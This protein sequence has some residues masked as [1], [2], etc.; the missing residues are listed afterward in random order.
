MR[1][2]R[3]TEVLVIGGGPAGYVAAIRLAQLGK[4]VLL[5]EKE[6]VGG[7]CVNWGCIPVKAL[8]HAAEVVRSAVEARPMGILFQKP[9]LDILSLYGWKGRIVER[10]VRGVEFLLKAN[11]VETLRGMARFVDYRQVE[12]IL[13]DG[14]DVLVE[15]ENVLVATGSRPVVLPGMETDGRRVIDSSGA[16]NVVDLP[17]RM[18][19]IGAGVIGLEFATIFSRLGSKVTVLELVDQVLP[20]TD[21]EIASMLKRL[22]SREGIDFRLG[23][24]VAGI[25]AG[26][27][28]VIQYSGKDGEQKV[29]TD[30]VLVAVGRVPL[31]DGLN[32]EAAGVA[33]DQ[34]G[35]I[36]TDGQLRTNVPNVSAIGDVRGGMLLAHKAMAEGI[37]FADNL[38]SGRQWS[39]K[40]VPAC[41][42]TDPEVAT[43]GMTEKEA[44]DAGRKVR[45]SRVPLSAIGRSLT[46]GRSEG[47]CKMVV[48]SD[49]DRVLGVGMVAP[50]ADALIA[51]AAVAVELGLTAAQIGSVVHPHPTMSELLFEAAEATHGRAV[52]IV[53]K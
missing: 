21:P 49:S 13:P 53:N 31:T 37:A 41:V 20:G 36:K 5:V 3:R 11:G 4:K 25:T 2:P 52:H 26:E 16:L 30:R 32:L 12:V 1:V 8:L 46:L 35:F 43:V 47:L 51:E 9:E 23:V 42:Y 19:V 29:E 39:F 14:S 18:V 33:V 44:V 38:A 27:S 22:M 24:K 15:A 7:V 45:V 28:P 48:D 6:R 50:Q 17:A 10:L 34:R 40:A